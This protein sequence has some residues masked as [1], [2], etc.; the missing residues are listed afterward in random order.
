MS[1]PDATVLSRLHDGLPID[2]ETMTTSRFRAWTPAVHTG[3]FILALVAIIALVA[4]LCLV[5]Y[6]Q[7]RQEAEATAKN[8]AEIISDDIQETFSR[9]ESDLHTF[10]VFVRPDDFAASVSAQ[11][12][13]DIEALMTSHVIRFPEVVNYRVFSAAGD[14]LFGA[15]RNPATFNVG[16][17]AWF[18]SLKDDPTLDLVISDVLIGKAMQVPTIILAVP[19]R[20][21][22]GRFLG[23]A[24]AA[25]D[26]THFQQLIDGPLIGSEGLIAIHRSDST[27]LLLRRPNAPHHVNEPVANA[28]LSRVTAGDQWGGIDFTSPV[29]GVARTT[30]FRRTQRY[31]LV[32]IV[33]LAHDD[34]LKAWTVQAWAAGA[35]TLAFELLLV[36]LFLR[37]RRTQRALDR[38]LLERRQAEAALR[39]SEQRYQ[40]LASG[41]FEGIAV[42]KEA[43]FIDANQQLLT[44]LGYS[45]EEL[46]GMRVADLLPPEDRQRVLDNIQNTRESHLEHAMIRK[47]GQRILVEGRGQESQ[48]GT[49]TVRITSLRDITAIKH[50]EDQLQAYRHHLEEL[51]KDRTA[52]LA[53]RERHLNVILNGIPG[54]V[55]YW[56][57]NLRSRFAN[58]TYHEWVGMRPGQIE[59]KHF[60][61]VFGAPI[62][63]LSQPIIQKVLQGQA[64]T[65]ERAYPLH[66]K[67]ERRRWWEIHYVPDRDGEQVLG[68]FV[69]GFDIDEL[70]RARE[71]AETANIAKSAFLANMSHEIRT[72]LNAVTGM[73]HL[74]RRGGLTPEQG[75]QLDKLEEASTHLLNVLNA[76][77]ELSKIEAGKFVIEEAPVA[78]AAV[79]ENVISLLQVKAQ[80]RGL[81]LAMDPPPPLPNL[82]GDP[83][84]LQQALLNYTSNAI[85]FTEA[86]GAVLRVKLLEQDVDGVLL[87][88]E[89]QDTGIGIEPEALPRLFAAFEQADNTTIRKYGGTGL[90]LAI[91]KKLAQMMGGD[92]GAESTF[93]AGSI[94]WFTA[95]LKKERGSRAV[96]DRLAQ[97][98]AKEALSRH[99]T[100]RVVLVAEDEPINR[101]VTRFLLEDVGLV[102][103][104]AEDGVEALRLAG[105][106]AC[107]LILMDMQMPRMDGLEA[108]R[109]IRLL[110]SGG[111]IPI[112]AMT[113]NAFAEDRERCFEAGMNDFVSKPARPDVLYATLL[114]W[115]GDCRS[116]EAPTQPR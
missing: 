115:L 38:D 23:A 102:V 31:P 7:S 105:Q 51:V 40:T 54:A 93:G 27:K 90:G 106:G 49:R 29:D 98:G 78:V 113:A 86:G 94:F 57:R 76:I 96:P 99:H 63:Q 100:G 9:A 44:M 28:V 43:R 58:P 62:Y 48:S 53:A 14:A 37:Q 19:I 89:V 95:R 47:D 55:A 73:A 88:F 56:D 11:R 85:K 42:T 83:T 17:R 111:R 101:E 10:A 24:N 75:A 70:K 59:G 68:F 36:A 81:Q 103:V 45:R 87:R 21:T 41:T 4:G 114:K 72:P 60:S 25:L 108:T 74:I 66:V 39:E 2:P 110:P 69:M 79:L 13:Y 77:L 8:L 5:S 84:R 116:S 104:T 12:R 52:A 71:Q 6:N 15:G 20:A 35:V 65:F 92:A 64:Q 61:E 32:T 80:A 67:P 30:A 97:E 46:I 3:L 26:M 34:F 112:L 33:G 91:T 107:A 16:D 22:N 50:A 82:L 1:E 18:A 109:R